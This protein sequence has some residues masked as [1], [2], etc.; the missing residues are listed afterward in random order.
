[1]TISVA[2]APWPLDLLKGVTLDL[3][4]QP[5]LHFLAS[6]DE[7]GSARFSGIPPATWDIRA[8]GPPE[9]TRGRGFAMPRL[10]QTGALAAS[11]VD[12]FTREV[13]APDGHTVFTVRAVPGEEATLEITVTA[14]ATAEAPFLVPV[15]Y[16]TGA[17]RAHLLAAVARQQGRLY[18]AME[19]PG[20]NPYGAWSAGE[21]VSP[22]NLAEWG[23]G[24]ITASVR[25]AR[26]YP[27]AA[28]FWKRIAEMAPPAAADAIRAA[29][30]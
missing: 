26:V 11:P 20:F 19:L 6:I 25:A 27:S 17:G 1:M 5:N 7:Q 24:V 29:E 15:T 10:E 18:T 21:R 23:P 16:E 9:V 13:H 28:K 2:N 12:S 30:L 8:L 22:G 14:A 4:I 3:R